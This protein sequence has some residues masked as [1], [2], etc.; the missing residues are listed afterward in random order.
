MLSENVKKYRKLKGWSQQKL[1]DK[2][3]ISYN[4]L[5]KLEQGKAKHPT[6]QTVV[7]IANALGVSVDELVK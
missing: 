6:I 1:A 2:A 7:K 3:K 4:A 5:T